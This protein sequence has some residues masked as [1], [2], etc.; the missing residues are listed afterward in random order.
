MSTSNSNIAQPS[1]GRR[2][3]LAFGN[4]FRTLSDADF[5][6]RVERIDQVVAEPT[7]AEPPKATAPIIK[8]ASPDAALQLL[9][10]LQRDARLIDFVQENLSGFSDAEIGAAA[11]VVHDGCRKVLAEHFTIASVRTEAEGSRITLNEGFDAAAVRLTGNVVGAAPFNGSLSH[12]GWRATEVRLPKLVGSHDATI[13]A[14][15]EVEL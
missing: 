5:A 14:P 1:L 7:P 12:R 9:S 11:R 10:L 2:I 13:L 8:Q 15:A 4:F 3:S 6:G